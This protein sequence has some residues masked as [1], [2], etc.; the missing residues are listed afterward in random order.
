MTPKQK[1]VILGIIFIG[2]VL[3]ETAIT[4]GVYFIL[5]KS[6]KRSIHRE[7]QTISDNI[8]DEFDQTMDIAKFTLNRTATFIRLYGPYLSVSTYTDMIQAN[9]SPIGAGIDTNIWIYK[10]PNAEL[11]QFQNFCR[12]NIT[13]NCT[14]FEYNF[15][16]QNF[17]PVA[18][19]RPYY[20]PII[21]YQSTNQ[22]T[23][24]IIG[25]DL[26]STS[27]TAQSI[28]VLLQNN[29]NFTATARISLSSPD[30]TNPYN[31]G[32][33]LS[34]LVYFNESLTD[35]DQ[36]YG[37]A[38]ITM[39]T[40]DIFNY[41]IDKLNISVQRNDMDLFVFDIT[42]DL[43]T[44]HTRNLSLL[45]HENKDEYSKI[46]FPTELHNDYSLIAINHTRFRRTW[47]IVFKFSNDFIRG[48]RNAQV[49]IIPCVMGA[50]FIM[51]D[52]IVVV[53]YLLFMAMITRAKIEREGKDVAVHMLGYVNHEVRNPL[54]V[55]KGLVQY[56]LDLL[57]E[58]DSARA[59]EPIQNDII[60]NKELHVNIISDLHTVA[61]ACDML[62]HIVTDI[63][64]IRK[65]ESKKLDLDYKIIKIDEF[66][67][68]LVK[69]V[70]QKINEKQTVAFKLEYDYNMLIRIDPFRL[71]QI[72]LN[73]L[74][75]A[76]KY[77]DEGSIIL[78][79][80]TNDEYIRF[81]ITD[82]G[83][84]ITE[85]AQQVI[86]QPF[87]QAAPHDASRYGG[88]GLGLYLC[89]MLTERMNGRVGF[90]SIYK[91]GSTFW[92]EFPIGETIN[93][94]NK[95]ELIPDV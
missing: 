56:N 39:R 58:L 71:K 13:P 17:G 73:Y 88:I 2:L 30:P 15:T 61:G 29:T 52:I 47:T 50:I 69:T 53:L 44:N 54:N 72:L 65:L 21:F 16:T 55:I 60:L 91:K 82:T 19:N 45:Y 31:Y 32:F 25:F 95:D 28:N 46:W 43:G 34:R 76:I 74:T 42:D 5:H 59:I 24:E 7:M 93:F 78:Q 89:K 35:L 4:V 36:I 27:A 62:E 68:D 41:A 87:H 37:A 75:N 81:S 85:Q 94:V 18:S 22:N 51:V 70:T 1:H 57:R 12:Q 33:V 84:G 92:S 9:S 79:V 49:I 90:I 67:K 40:G 66:M 14:I 38:L 20:W 8:I 63:L 77:T 86:F 48:S 3:V 83:R 64:D 23:S 6:D 10:L 80:T 11:Y 26:Y